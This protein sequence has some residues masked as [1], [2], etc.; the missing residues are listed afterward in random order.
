MVKK[1][2][3]WYSAGEMPFKKRA[4]HTAF[5]FNDKLYVVGGL[6]FDEFKNII[7]MND[8]WV[9]DDGMNWQCIKGKLLEFMPRGGH[10]CALFRNKV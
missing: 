10:A 1:G 2:L 6:S 4:G 5:V 7:D 8:V 9:T 3:H